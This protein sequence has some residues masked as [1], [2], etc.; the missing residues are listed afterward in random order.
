MLLTPVP[1]GMGIVELPVIK[2]ADDEGTMIDT[3]VPE[4]VGTEELSVTIGPD[5]E[6]LVALGISE[7]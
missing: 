5:A 6:G 4:D 3:P 7:D 1:V 2:G